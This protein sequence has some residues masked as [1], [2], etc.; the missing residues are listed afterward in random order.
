MKKILYLFLLLFCFSQI[1]ISQIDLN[2]DKTISLEKNENYTPYEY[3]SNGV[4]RIGSSMGREAMNN[5]KEEFDIFI[6][7][8]KYSYEIISDEVIYA[9]GKRDWTWTFIFRLKDSLGNTLITKK[10]AKKQILDLKE[11]LDLGV[12]TQS[13][14][15][16]KAKSLKAILLSQ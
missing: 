15:D 2:I 4:Y 10:E 1:G 8:N 13:E 16:D 7:R 5:I 3:I 14:Y 9:M 11:L 12:I 6:E